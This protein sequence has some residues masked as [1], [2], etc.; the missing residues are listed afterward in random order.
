M[1]EQ[2][3]RPNVLLFFTD[4]QRWDTVGAYGNPMGLTP[5]LDAMAQRGTLFR[6]AFTCQP[7]CAPARACIQTGRYATEHGVWRNAIPLSPK[8][9]T[10]GHRLRAQ[11]Y[12]TAYIG[13]W[14]LAAVDTKPVP[15]EHRSGY[16]YWLASDTLEFTSRP[17]DVT[18]FGSDGGAVRLPGYRV[19]A[20]TDAAI[21]YL[22]RRTS[23]RPFFLTVSFIEPHQ[24]NDLGKLCAPDGYAA[25]Y[26]S[27]EYVPWDLVGTGGDWRR[28]LPAYYGMVRRL[29]ESLGRL[30]EAIERLHLSDDTVVLFLS[31]HG[32][33]FRT[34]NAEYKRSPHD[35]SIRIPL[36]AQ[37]P[38][39]EGGGIVDELAS[40]ID[41]APTLLERAG[42]PIPETFRGRSLLG[43]LDGS[44]TS[45]PD[46]VFIQISESQVGRAIRTKK[47]LYS[48]HAPDKEGWKE[49]AS[50][51]YIE[52]YLYDLE[53][54]P[55]QLLNLVRQDG[56]RT[57]REEMR[58][59]LLARMRRAG[60][61]EPRIRP[62][63]TPEQDA[64]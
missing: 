61:A 44:A 18:M 27:P 59:R 52:E 36:V 41:I 31:D 20:L 56:L 16:D 64:P 40:L 28:E 55:W 33:H 54:D 26:A 8:A 30:L 23:D 47:W 4:Q 17:Y 5:Q 39:F 50:D 11:G 10:I 63:S 58:G 3:R 15:P 24:Q 19:D 62:A 60:E 13:K 43:L 12:E 7:V 57:V 45:W 49:P 51:R 53:E 32:C 25:R 1:L 48:V 22:E 2:A 6:H 42:A 46:D 29:D 14:H 9:V 21:A 38:G 35:S 34:R 37:G